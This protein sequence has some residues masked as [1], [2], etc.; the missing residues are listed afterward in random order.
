MNPKSNRSE[1]LLGGAQEPA[2][3]GGPGVTNHVPQKFS[4]KGQ[5]RN[6]IVPRR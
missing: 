6:Q 4:A 1:F 3:K 5:P 2:F